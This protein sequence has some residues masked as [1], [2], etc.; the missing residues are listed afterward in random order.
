[1]IE[2]IENEIRLD[3][4]IE[5]KENQNTPL[6][7][8]KIFLNVV[9]DKMIDVFEDD[10]YDAGADEEDVTYFRNKISHRTQEEILGVLSLPKDVR[11]I[12]FK[13]SFA[14]AEAGNFAI[15]RILHTAIE[16]H[17]KYG[18][19]LGYHVSSKDIQP[20]KGGWNISA[21]EVD[22]RDDMKMA[23]Y[24]LDYEHFYR[25]KP[26]KYI[27][28][29]RAETG[30][31]SSHKKDTSNRWSR[32]VSLSVVDRVALSEVDEIVD[33]TYKEALKKRHISETE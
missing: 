2:R 3:N 21:T 17:K 24:S 25:K 27:Y 8:E 15:D 33:K 14:E 10:L 1:M 32:A 26:A 29:V 31:N 12:L 6:L 20:T 19:T 13:K 18:Y 30:E 16:G 4:K 11:T 7:R 23:Y 9:F 28:F 22:D 5:K